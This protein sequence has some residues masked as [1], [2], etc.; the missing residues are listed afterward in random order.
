M[1]EI[2]RPQII[3]DSFQRFSVGSHECSR[4]CLEVH[5]KLRIKCLSLIISSRV[6]IAGCEND[7]FAIKSPVIESLNSEEFVDFDSI[8]EPVHVQF[9]DPANEE[10]IEQWSLNF[11][12]SDTYVELDHVHQHAVVL[13]R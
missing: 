10:V 4:A 9:I 8:L 11:N 6:S 3:R 12:P 2:T 7:W 13:L 1:I 5:R